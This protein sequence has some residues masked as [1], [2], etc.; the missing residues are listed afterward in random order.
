MKETEKLRNPE[1]IKL[2]DNGCGNKDISKFME[3]LAVSYMLHVFCHRGNFHYC[4]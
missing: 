3:K 1:Y 2:R 4:R